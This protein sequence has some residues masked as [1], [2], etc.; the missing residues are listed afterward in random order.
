LLLLL[1]ALLLAACGSLPFIGSAPPAP[2]ATPQ[3]TVS[4]S[5]A[6][7]PGGA[8]GV[9]SPAGPATPTTAAAPTAEPDELAAL[10]AAQRQPHDR[11]VMARTLAGQPDASMVARTTPLDVAVGHVRDFWVNDITDNSNYA[12]AA[13]LR[14]A[15][16]VVLMYVEQGLELDQAALEEAAQTFEQQIYPR[17]RELFG[18]EWQ[19]GV[20]GDPRIVIL[21]VGSMSGGVI[22]YYSP[23]DSVPQ[24]VNRFSNEHEMFYMNA[25]TIPPGSTSYLDTLAHEFQHMIHWNEQ[26]STSTWFNEGN[27]TLAEDLNGFVNHHFVATFLYE[28]DVQLTAWGELPGSSLA[29]YGASHLFMRYVYAQYAG[30]AGL[31]EL[32]RADAGNNLEA[33][34]QLARE[35]RPDIADFGDLLAD[36]SLANLLNDP[37]LADG[38]YA[39]NP[40]QVGITLLPEEVR[41]VSLRAGTSTL[42]VS[43]FGTDYHKLPPGPHTLNFAGDTSVHLTGAL[44]RGTYAWWSGRSDNSVATLTRAFDLRDLDSATLQ[45]DTWYEIEQDYDYAFVSVS[46]DEGATW[47]T[48]VGNHTT[49]DDPHGGNYGHGLTGVSGLPGEPTSIEERGRWITETMDLSPYA[50]QQ[51]LVRFWQITDEGFNAPGILLDN[52]RIPELGYSDD[53]EAGNGGWQASGFVR[54]DGALAQDWELRLVRTAADGAVQIETLPVDAAGEASATL[55]EGE[56][57]VLLVMATTPYTTEPASYQVTVTAEE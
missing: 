8:G 46:T 36:W 56:Q 11:V 52:I 38:R 40:E 23:R 26:R 27:S 30:E 39:Y 44:P 14:Y 25:G 18:S 19:P 9:A 10:G 21:N 37:T 17:T 6:A 42:D 54:V 45:F 50:G 3:P 7:T 32:V 5:P 29:H 20:D 43:Q 16:P 22:G 33:F 55:S 53:V 48:L 28:P 51:V 12:V 47:Q 24:D 31:V 1:V 57:G 49:T 4:E 2:T 15:G 35:T 13:E 41:P 34:V